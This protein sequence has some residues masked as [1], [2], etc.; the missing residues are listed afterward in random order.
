[1]R[2][3]VDAILF[4]IDGTL[5]DSTAAVE[6]SWRTWAGRRGLDA[7][8]I[9]RICHGRRSE[10]TIALLL[11]PAQCPAGVAELEQLETTDLDDVI[12]LPATQTLLKRL[13]DDRWAAVTSGSRALMRA[14]LS[15]A[16]LP[17][18]KVLISAE[19]VSAGKP[20]PQGYLRAAAALGY[21]VTRCLVVEDAPAGIEA[22]RA[23]G[24]QVLAVATSH[25]ESELT[26]AH[27]VI[28]NLEDCNVVCTAGAMRVT[29]PSWHG[30]ATDGRT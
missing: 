7:E 22:G 14:R 19:D 9:L 1:V 21:D 23:A 8:A 3:D 11:P 24:A 20:D 6:R 27:A 10:D 17:V 25:D 18:P 2:F 30:R 26:S 29:T 16:G 28:A 5:V 4:D 12:A 13:P 15:A